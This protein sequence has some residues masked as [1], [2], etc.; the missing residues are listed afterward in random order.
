[1]GRVNTS[2]FPEP[3]KAMPIMSRPDKMAG[4]P[5]DEDN[6][7]IIS[8]LKTSKA[9]YHIDKNGLTLNLNGGGGNDSFLL[10]A[11]DDGVGKFHFFEGLAWGWNLW[12]TKREVGNGMATSSH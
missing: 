2:V 10:E 4:M 3:V 6:I 9:H 5:G 8:Q 11:F 1:M 12:K 7:S